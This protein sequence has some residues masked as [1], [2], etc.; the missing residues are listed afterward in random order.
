MDVL[1]QRRLSYDKI[2]AEYDAYRPGYPVECLDYLVAH[3]GLN[4]AS[5]VLEIGCGTGQFTGLLGAFGCTVDALDASAGMITFAQDKHP[6][7]NVQFYASSFEDFAVSGNLYDVIVSAT[8][9]H[10]VQPE[11]RMDKTAQLLKPGGALAFLY[12]HYA[13]DPI[14][15]EVQAV[16]EAVLAL[17][18]HKVPVLDD[19]H[20]LIFKDMLQSQLFS[21]GMMVCFHNPVRYDT[22]AYLGMQSTHSYQNTLQPQQKEALMAGMR[23]VII[24]HGGIVEVGYETRLFGFRKV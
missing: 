21:D 7:P 19:K 23:E 14:R 5:R 2:V 9:F 12:N 1:E 13:E 15:L 4:P 16:Y 22:Q 18:T 24:R 20:E 17:P 6:L 11:A 8:A 3:Y 10:W